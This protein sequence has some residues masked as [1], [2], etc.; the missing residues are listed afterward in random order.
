MSAK[1]MIAIILPEACQAR[2]HSFE[3]FV[4]L[5]HQKK[6]E[7]AFHAVKICPASNAVLQ[8]ELTWRYR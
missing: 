1:V 5:C 4:E 8:W 6:A 2:I 7:T 3:G